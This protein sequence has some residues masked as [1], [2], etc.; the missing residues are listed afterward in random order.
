MVNYLSL[1][2]YLSIY[3]SKGGG[4]LADK[5]RASAPPPQRDTAAPATDGPPPTAAAD[6]AAAAK[7][8]NEGERVA[9]LRQPVVQR[10]VR[11]L[12]A[13]RGGDRCSGQLR[14]LRQPHPGC[15]APA[16]QGRD[17]GEAGALHRAGW[18]G[19][20]GS[21]R[22]ARAADLH[23][24]RQEVHPPPAGPLPG[25]RRGTEV[26]PSPPPCLATCLHAHDMH[27]HMCMHMCMCMP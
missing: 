7:G 3:L 11:R 8:A 26:R 6:F 18:H 14:A 17:G 25:H 1:S 19:L 13:P 9:P 15:R 20:P 16:Y 24:R 5:R 12:R 10:E 22:P 27:M 4:I 21:R 23:R 2:I